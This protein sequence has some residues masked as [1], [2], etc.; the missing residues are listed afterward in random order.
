LHGGDYAREEF[1]LKDDR[2]AIAAEGGALSRIP[3][4]E[5]FSRTRSPMQTTRKYAF[6]FPSHMS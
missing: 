4:F 1:E 6:G 3:D 5:F 2:K